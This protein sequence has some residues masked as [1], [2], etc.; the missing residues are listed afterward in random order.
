MKALISL[1]LICLLPLSNVALGQIAKERISPGQRY[2]FLLYAEN[3]LNVS[4]PD[5]IIELILKKVRSKFPSF[6]PKA[7]F[8]TYQE[9]EIPS[10]LC[11][12]PAGFRHDKEE[13]P[14]TIVFVSTFAPFEKKKFQIVWQT[15]TVIEH[16][17][18]KM[19]QAAL[20]VKVDYRKID[21]YYTGGKFVDVDSATVPSD[22]F[23]HDAL[24]RIEGP[25][26]ESDR[27]VYRYYLDSR[28]R[29]DIFGKRTHDLVLQ[30]IGQNDLVSDSKESYSNMLDWGMDIFKVGESLGIGSIAMWQDSKVAT[31][32]KVDKVTC[33]VL[34]G[35]I[36]SGV[37]TEYAGWKVGSGMHDLF[38][39][40][41]I[42]AGSRL[43]KVVA[44]VSGDSVQLCT[45]LAKHEGC[46]LI[47]SENTAEG[48][49][50]YTAMYGK[51]SLSG[52]N[53]ELR[54]FTGEATSRR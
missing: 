39:D 15:D 41:S 37:L 34:N 20:G 35:P 49:W 9:K 27:I 51:Q 18:P 5:Q 46:D 42:S 13:T 28:N 22:H 7:F 53:W 54:S 14:G 3:P 44:S 19:T 10:Q 23:A 30:E 2:S 31:V 45:G 47:R 4:R 40:V 25:G 21:G 8:V 50:G 6:N 24:Y 11:E 48:K 33:R 38:S 29:N 36:E 26:W 1:A 52:D 43:T 32:S 12:E 17:Y 16:Q